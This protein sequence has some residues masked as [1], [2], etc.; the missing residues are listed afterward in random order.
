MPSIKTLINSDYQSVKTPETESLIENALKGLVPSATPVLRQVSGIP[1]AGKSTYCASHLEKNFLMLGFDKIMTTLSGYQ[2]ELKTNGAV[3]AFQ[4]YEMP[5]RIIGYELLRRALKL[6][7]NIMFE[8]S[9]AN[10]AHL[11]LFENLPKIGYKTRVDF[12]LC[13]TALASQRA[14]ERAEKINRY[15]PETLIKDR[16]AGLKQYMKAYKKL[17]FSVFFFDGTDNFRPLKKI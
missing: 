11:E 16:A 15:V 14:K 5:A 8:H 7:L 4:K 10:C 1:G 2:Q 12:I 9:G 17:A 6:R 13:N 3:A